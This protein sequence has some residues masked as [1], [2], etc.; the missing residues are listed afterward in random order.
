MWSPSP[1]LLLSTQPSSI[2]FNNPLYST[3]KATICRTISLIMCQCICCWCKASLGVVEHGI[4]KTRRAW[5]RNWLWPKLE[6][7][8]LAEQFKHVALASDAI[9]L[10]W[11]N[12]QVVSLM[13]ILHDTVTL[14][15]EFSL[16][17]SL[18]TIRCYWKPKEFRESRARYLSSYY[19]NICLYRASILA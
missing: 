16:K 18:G 5:M 8:C 14:R 6:K 10:P 7:T 11:T 4:L 15:T 1:P 3:V 2:D 9:M 13:M 12:I 19:H 17:I